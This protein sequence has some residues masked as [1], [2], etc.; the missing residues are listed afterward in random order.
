M[1]S[2][3]ID[4]YSPT[5]QAYPTI[6]VEELIVQLCTSVGSRGITTGDHSTNTMKENPMILKI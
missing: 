1:T 6:P 3:I 2:I 5:M 4:T